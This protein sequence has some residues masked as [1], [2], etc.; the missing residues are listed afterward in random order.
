MRTVLYMYLG[1]KVGYAL[2]QIVAKVLTY[3][4]GYTLIGIAKTLRGIKR[5][6]K[7]SVRRLAA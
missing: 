4:I 3:T 1:W 7:Y 6:A 5:L 2:G